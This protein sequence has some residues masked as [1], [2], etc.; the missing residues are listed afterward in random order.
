MKDVSKNLG[1]PAGLRPGRLVGATWAQGGVRSGSV[2]AP[3]S[4]A[5]IS[6]V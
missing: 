4:S 3:S 1:P 6:H 2:A 5:T